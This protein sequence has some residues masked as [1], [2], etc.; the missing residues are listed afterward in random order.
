MTDMTQSHRHLAQFN[1]ARIRYP[2]DDPR[3]VAFVDNV[4]RVNGLAEMIDGFVWRLQTEDGNATAIQAFA[5][6]AAGSAGVIVNLS[7]KK[8]VHGYQ[9]VAG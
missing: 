9:L 1:I 6:D 7:A 3:M 4:Q 5:W 2:L 8:G